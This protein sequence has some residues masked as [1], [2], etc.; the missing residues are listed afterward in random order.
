MASAELQSYIEDRLRD[1]D[2][3]MDLSAG[4]P[5]QVR[6]IAPILS[7]LGTDPFET[8]IDSFIVTR[9]QQEFPQLFAGD[10]SAVRDTF[11]KPL[12]TILEPFKRE[13]QS[14]K[15]GQSLKDPTALSDSDADSLVANVFDERP[16]G[17][18][19]S[20]VVRVYYTNPTNVQVEITTRFYTAGGLNFFPANPSSMTAEEMVFNRQG[21]LYF[22]DVISKAEAQ[23]DQYNVDANLITGVSGLFG[24]VKVTNPRK[25]ENG[26]ARLDTASFVAQAREALT[27]RSL[28]TRRGAN[29]RVKDVFE[30]EMR[31]VQVIGAND[32]E[33]MRDILVATSPGHAWMLGSVMLYK[34]VAY[35]RV[36]VVDGD[37]V[38]PPVPGDQLFVYLDQYTGQGEGSS[39]YWG[40][41][42]QKDRFVRLTV[43][44]VMAF[45]FG[46]SAP[47]QDAFFVRWSGTF[48]VTM[49]DFVS[50]EGGFI[51]KGTIKVSSLPSVG[52]VD[53]T[54]NNQE[55]HVF[56][57]T[58][59]Y[60][61]PS[62]QTTSK[63][64]LPTLVDSDSFLQR[65]TLASSSGSNVVMDIISRGS[66]GIS[67]AEAF[68]FFAAGVS[69]G[70]LLTVDAGDDAGT[71]VVGKVTGPQAS[72]FVPSMLYLTANLTRS[73]DHIRY[74]VTKS[75]TVDPFEP[76]VKKLPF[77]DVSANDLQTTISSNLFRFSVNTLDYGAK[78]GDTIRVKTGFDAGDFKITGFHASYGGQGVLVDRNASSTNANVEYELFTAQDPIAKPLVRVKDI[79]LLDSAQKSTGI[80]VPPADSVAVVPTSDF[81]SAQVRGWSQ[82]DSG[83]VL[84]AFNGFVS[85]NVAA[86]S[87]D[88]RYSQGYDPV[89][90]GTYKGM[91]FSDG[92]QA[93]LLF[94]SDSFSSCS[95]F[96]ATSEDTSASAN[97][98]PIDPKPGDA[99]TLKNG[100]NKGS[101]HIQDVKKW[102][103]RVGN[104][105][106]GRDVW[107]YFIKIYGTFPVD[108]FG[109]LIA[110]LQSAGVSV[111]SLTDTS[112]HSFPSFFTNFFTSIGSSLD[113]AILSLGGI[114]P[115]P[116]ALQATAE[117]MLQVSYAW[118]DPARGVL[119]SYFTRPQLFQQHTA[120]H[121]SPTLYEY[122]AKDGTLVYFRPD[123]GRY[124]KHQLVP[125]RLTSDADMA[126]LPRDVSVA[127]S[128]LSF[129]DE[130]R[131]A[132]FAQGVQPGDT[133]ELHEELFLYTLA[134]IFPA[135]KTVAGSSTVQ[136]PAGPTNLFPANIV[137]NLISIEQGVDKDVYKVL[138]RLDDKT[139]V[140][141]RP[142]SV[143][144]P[145]PL[146]SGQLSF[147]YDGS[148][149]K[150]I[151][152]AGSLF[153]ADMVGKYVTI[154]ASGYNPVT[155]IGYEGSYR[156]TSVVD[157]HNLYISRLQNFGTAVLHGWFVVTDAPDTDP[158]A[159]G[160]TGGT[161]AVGV[162]PIRVY[163]E[164]AGQYPVTDVNT[165]P[166]VSQVTV[167]GSPKAGYAQPYAFFRTN[168]RRVNPT[169]M[170]ENRDG[171]LYFFDTEVV[172]LSPDDASN[173][174]KDSYLTAVDG[175]FESFG[176]RF[177]VDDNTLSYST[178]E[179]AS[180]EVP[181]RI[182]PVGVPDSLDGELN[183]VGVPVQIDY[184]AAD[185]V[186]RLQEF[187]E[188]SEDRVTS[189][190]LLARHFLPAYVS[191][192]ASYSG[193]SAPSVVAEDI[194]SYIDMLSI[195]TPVD[196]SE[197]EKL[198]DQR[199]GNPDTPTKAIITIHDWDRR[200]W[201]EFGENKLGGTDTLV[202]YNGT[203]RVSALIS[204]PDV[205]GQS[206]TPDGERINLT[207]T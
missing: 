43:E 182:L 32:P 130:S 166:S 137:G 70:D 73:A 115:G 75:I 45:D 6:F 207:R 154:F 59:I 76:K 40:T 136:V 16:Q 54:I 14:V 38:T 93:E 104:S 46:G 71:Y 120:L 58:D 146:A 178:K 118:G 122:K 110:F 126:D 201:V 157:A 172:S 11:A 164:V 193:G 87:G 12:I 187:I 2:P 57:H 35:V 185:V 18:Y 176:Y 149:N 144:T 167:Q 42:P 10:P 51:K 9:F 173:I 180:L 205:S 128:V 184:E 132:M 142:L 190:N 34:K 91:V 25:F 69:P 64:V 48:P 140:L 158:A 88:R 107:L 33:M 5:A 150:I 29:A 147:Y 92:S 109:Q 27:E 117:S 108:V 199:G 155:G 90:G 1:L 145:T 44:E 99:L 98:P 129:S 179:T 191:Y 15:R 116:A 141:D 36:R 50:V 194:I 131:A 148:N 3:S 168:L 156:I 134:N 65:D 106:S 23:G 95:Y 89:N 83:Y 174:S 195:E 123:P 67:I 20:G 8:D 4:S 85:N 203:P 192:D 62:L 68:D 202:P 183:L 125:G 177:H 119:R 153:T 94:P 171:F 17:S 204:T 170:T 127:G 138:D 189:A 31:S 103:Y 47:Y 22:M 133:L 21:S 72:P 102:R 24:A 53:L 186:A 198:I 151:S 181:I 111:P 121:A 79:L 100:P 82:V 160:S 162:R 30:A 97:Y 105:G 112:T 206:P 159:L 26:T 84:P 28:V 13:T 80:S 169:E 139:L 49:P 196:V 152:L 63:A 143:S 81:T 161:E 86:T 163:D 7:Y 77:G 114:S 37:T 101:Y 124:E 39:A 78:I 200:M 188:S 197:I 66:D 41:L 175:S 60:A 74:R 19:S 96:L 135:V 52:A 61:R 55:V 113:A 165:D 56:G